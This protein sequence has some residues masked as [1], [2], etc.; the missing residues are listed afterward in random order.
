MMHQGQRL[1][2]E[3]K[4]DSERATK[5]R[6]SKP[7]L[8]GARVVEHIPSTVPPKT[9]PQ[10]VLDKMATATMSAP[11]PVPMK[12]A[13]PGGL[14]PPSDVHPDVPSDDSETLLQE[15]AHYKQVIHDCMLSEVEGNP[16]PEE[17]ALNR[18]NEYAQ[19]RE[20]RLRR[21]SAKHTTKQAQEYQDNALE[22]VRALRLPDQGYRELMHKEND[23]LALETVLSFDSDDD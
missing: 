18:A 2:D 15:E 6:V 12:V 21:K 1:K 20:Q 5:A 23:V 17:A 9:P 14:H 8:K 10:E 3:E 4:A 7:K 13:P 19:T 16:M 11:M 22:V